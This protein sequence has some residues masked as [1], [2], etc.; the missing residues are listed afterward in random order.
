[1]PFDR[2]YDDA[3]R[4]AATAQVLERRAANPELRSIMRDVAAEFNVG[5]Q[6]LRGWVHKATPAT[7]P[8][9]KPAVEPEK[10]AKR[11]PHFSP[12]V[13]THAE[14]EPD[15]DL[16]VP[17]PVVEYH[18]PASTATDSYVAGL[19]AEVARL[20]EANTTFKATIRILLGE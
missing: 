14:V 17:A 19:E 15:A 3:T 1:M 7:E 8:E 11:R 6:S 5:Q 9:T 20:R 16:D 4:E 12:V 2:K 18:A 13:T 10:K